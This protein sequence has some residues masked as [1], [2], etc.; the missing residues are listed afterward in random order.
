MSNEFTSSVLE[1]LEIPQGEPSGEEA[2]YKEQ[3]KYSGRSLASELGH[4]RD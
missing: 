3:Q 2:S 4:L 1:A